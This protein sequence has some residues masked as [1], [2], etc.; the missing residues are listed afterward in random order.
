M[1]KRLSSFIAATA[2]LGMVNTVQADPNLINTYSA[3]GYKHKVVK[4]CEEHYTFN[5]NKGN[6]ELVQDSIESHQALGPTGT[7]LIINS[8][9]KLSVELI[10]SEPR[11]LVY[12]AIDGNGH[13]IERISTLNTNVSRVFELPD[14]HEQV[15]IGLY[16]ACALV[17]SV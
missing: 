15:H 7:R 9:Y 1:K 2:L 12:R 17:P 10:D 14:G 8:D 4:G 3:T 6:L 16:K 5:R 11:A 13:S